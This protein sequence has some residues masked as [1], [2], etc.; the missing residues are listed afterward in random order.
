MTKLATDKTKTPQLIS[1]L[2]LVI[3]FFKENNWSFSQ[4]ES[5]PILKIAYQGENGEW[6]CIARTREDPSQL[7]FYSIFPM[8]IP[9]KKRVA[10]AEFLTRINY[11]LIVGNFEMDFQ[12][13]EVRYKT[14]SID[15]ENNPLALESIRK[16]IFV[17]VM[18]MD[19]YL[20]GI[21]SVIYANIP[22]AQAIKQIE[23]QADLKDD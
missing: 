15:L 17:N 13:G 7:V 20:P 10:I 2:E 21:M 1:T 23:E 3:N 4:H 11:G 5:E 14:Y 12:D 9:E 18:T 22:L 19:K 16:L 8:N 6:S